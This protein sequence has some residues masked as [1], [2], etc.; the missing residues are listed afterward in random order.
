MLHNKSPIASWLGDG[1]KTTISK[2]P[3]VNDNHTTVT[4]KDNAD[5]PRTNSSTDV[6]QRPKAT[7]T[8]AFHFVARYINI[9]IYIYNN[10]EVQQQIYIYLRV[11]MS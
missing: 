7:I 6:C 9:Y 5:R 1:S 3:S 4:A 8:N 10:N 2:L 11:K